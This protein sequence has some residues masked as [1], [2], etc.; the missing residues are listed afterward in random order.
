MRPKAVTVIGL[1]WTS[2]R[3]PIH[4]VISFRNVPSVVEVTKGVWANALLVVKIANATNRIRCFSQGK[5]FAD[6]KSNLLLFVHIITP[7]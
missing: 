1:D 2:I 3:M 4:A 7:F 5:M 6:S